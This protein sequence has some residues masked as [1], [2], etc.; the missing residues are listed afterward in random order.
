MS[1]MVERID[2]SRRDE[3]WQLCLDE[4]PGDDAAQL[5]KYNVLLRAEWDTIPNPWGGA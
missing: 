1:A 5:H 2:G 4:F 3:L